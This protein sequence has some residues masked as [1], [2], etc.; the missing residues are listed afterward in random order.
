MPDFTVTENDKEDLNNFFEKIKP[1]THVGSGTSDERSREHTIA[2]FLMM[3]E[4]KQFILDSKKQ[5]RWLLFGTW[6][7]AIATCGMAIAT[8]VMAFSR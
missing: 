1:F 5:T 6:V 4:Q 7:M 2:L 3:K 8:W